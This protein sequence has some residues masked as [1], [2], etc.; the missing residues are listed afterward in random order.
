MR[1]SRS[2][3]PTT[4][5]LH[6][7]RRTA[8]GS[9]SF[10]KS[11]LRRIAI[12]GTSLQEV[13]DAP[14]ARGGTWCGDDFIYYAPTN[15]SGLWKVA[16]SGGT[17]V[18]L[19]KPDPKASEISHRYPRALAGGKALLFMVWTGP[20]SDEHRIEYLSIA[21]GARQLVVPNADGPISIVNGQIVYSGRQDTLLSAPWNPSRP[22]SAGCRA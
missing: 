5:G 11:K 1:R 16:A 17:P 2:K 22:S 10:R 20:G 7:F 12:G 9:D 3:G 15:T 4:R 21:D 8:D 14:D 13:A 19:T 18:E 6:S